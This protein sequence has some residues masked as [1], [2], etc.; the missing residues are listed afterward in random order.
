[1]KAYVTRKLHLRKGEEGPSGLGA[2]SSEGLGLPEG[3]V[4]HPLGFYLLRKA[5]ASRSAVEHNKAGDSE[6]GFFCCCCF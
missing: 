3:S 1:M 5:Q 6:T 2:G 4:G